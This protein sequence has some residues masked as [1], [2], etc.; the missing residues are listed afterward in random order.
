MIDSG[1]GATQVNKLLT[2]LNIP[3]ISFDSIKRH[4]EFVGEA[5]LKSAE[6][7]M[8]AAITKEKYLTW[9]I[10][11]IVKSINLNCII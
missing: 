9:Y 4:E 11:F 2:T 6:D 5:L 8:E 3:S 1:L 10:K 7:C